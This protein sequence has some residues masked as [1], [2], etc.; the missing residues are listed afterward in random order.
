MNYSIL[1]SL[2]TS[3]LLILFLSCMS[4]SELSAQIQEKSHD[5][6][7]VCNNLAE[8]QQAIGYPKEAA[9]NGIEGKVLLKVLVDQNGNIA[10][11]KIVEGAPKLLAASVEKHISSLTFS[12]GEKNGKA[13]STW[14]TLPF[15]FK[16]SK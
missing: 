12:P 9:K 16:L 15:Q 3:S 1:K 13:V 4:I 10:E 8:V 6:Y 7:P 14:M 5:K 11:S 2:F